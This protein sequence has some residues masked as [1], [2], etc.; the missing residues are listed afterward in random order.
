MVHIFDVDYTL[1]KKPSSYYYL[2]EALRKK[3]IR[4]RQL[5]QLPFEYVRY[6]LGFANHSFIETAV[7]RFSGFDKNSMVSL[8]N[9]CFDHFVKPD[10][11]T[12]AVELIAGLK[13]SG[14]RIILA[15]SSFRIIVQPLQDYLDAETSIASELE[16][17]DGK[18]SGRLA[19]KSIFGSNKLEAVKAWLCEQNID[20]ATVRFY[21]DSYTDLPLLDY[22]GYPVAVNPDPILRRVA[23]KNGWEI[24]KFKE[25][26]GKVAHVKP[27]REFSKRQ[28]TRC[29]EV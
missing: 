26:L 29:D 7:E 24:I 16:F 28:F 14:A 19:G 27:D 8:A 20:A 22:C 1:V 4:F 21:S 23:L 17:I 12:G 15:T 11:Y 2:K 5:K 25:T 6:K 13:E 3:F 10:L 9:H 18:T